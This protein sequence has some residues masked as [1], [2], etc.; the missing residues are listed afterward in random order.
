HSISHACVGDDCECT[1]PAVVDDM[2]I[3]RGIEAARLPGVVL[4]IGNFDGVHRGHR[5]LID[6]GVELA[7]TAG[8]QLVAMTFEP[9]PAAI[10]T[11]DRV[12]PTLTPLHEKLRLLEAAGVDAV[13]V[14]ESRPD[15]FQL[16]AENFIREIIVE[17]FRPV[18]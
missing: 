1:N 6:R 4:S 2:Q 5:A 8:T 3:L 14:V 15:F 13:A 10:L 18:A 11:P 9:H 12:P 17:R 16:S 7:R